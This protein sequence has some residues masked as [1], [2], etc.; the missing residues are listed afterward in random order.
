M[1]TLR[2]IATASILAAASLTV[3]AAPP[4]QASGT[5][6]FYLSAGDYFASGSWSIT[7]PPNFGTSWQSGCGGTTCYEG[8]AQ[9]NW[10]VESST[11]SVFWCNNPNGTYPRYRAYSN[12]YGYQYQ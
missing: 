7:A 5:H 11:S 10:Y 9:C 4:A 12:G 6:S 2:R 3:G 8:T 1:K